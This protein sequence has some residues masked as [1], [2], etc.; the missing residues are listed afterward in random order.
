MNG[1]QTLGRLANSTLLKLCSDVMRQIIT[2]VI[3][4]ISLRQ[5][6]RHSN[7]RVVKL[8]WIIGLRVNC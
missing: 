3:P 2:V 8:K 5:K 7:R 1:L 6:Q 4:R